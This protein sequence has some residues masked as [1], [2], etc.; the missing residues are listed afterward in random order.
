MMKNTLQ[1][2]LD[3]PEQKTDVN[4]HVYSKFTQ[5]LRQSD[6]SVEFSTQFNSSELLKNVYYELYV[7]NGPKN[8]L[9]L[10]PTE[11][12]TSDANNNYFHVYFLKTHPSFIN[13]TTIPKF[14]INKQ[15]YY[16]KLAIDNI[17][18]ISDNT[19]QTSTSTSYSSDT[20]T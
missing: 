14:F 10:H 2:L 9:L 6:F 7:E 5:Y 1:R 13:L 16:I 18:S 4:F 19:S 17:F 15:N 3:S 12:Y 11:I 8:C 20:T